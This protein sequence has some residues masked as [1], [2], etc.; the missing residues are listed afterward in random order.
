M[1]ATWVCTHDC[2]HAQAMDRLVGICGITGGAARVSGTE[3]TNTHAP[4]YLN[5]R[6]E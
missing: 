2:I 3:A 6:R 4:S 1:N 5:M